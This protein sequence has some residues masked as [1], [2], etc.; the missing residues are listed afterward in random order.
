[1]ILP[2]GAESFTDGIRVGT[3][4]YHHLAKLIGKRYGVAA[5]LIGDEGGF[6]VPQIKD[7]N[8]TL[9]LIMDAIEDAG[10]GGKVDIGLDV[11]SS[12]FFTKDGKYDVSIKTGKKDR[13][14]DYKEMTELY[15]KLCKK[16]PIVTIEDPF[17][18]DDFKA[19]TYMQSKLGD[20]V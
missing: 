3:E 7:E 15:G 9:E 1:M 6:G 10:H 14:Y 13:V 18:Q 8:E 17:D 5:T 12:E 16:Y 20:K 19:Y 11:A 4:V 2:T